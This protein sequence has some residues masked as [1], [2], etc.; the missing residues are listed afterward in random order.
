MK[1]GTRKKEDIRVKQFM[2]SNIE[3]KQKYRETLQH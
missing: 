3:D 1:I 2:N